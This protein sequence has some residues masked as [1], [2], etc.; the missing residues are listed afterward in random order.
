MAC[1][2]R[3]F[4]DGHRSV[5]LRSASDLLKVRGSFL[6]SS[7]I[8]SKNFQQT[9]FR[10][11]SECDK[12]LRILQRQNREYKP[13]LINSALWQMVTRLRHQVGAQHSQ[14]YLALVRRLPFDK[15]Y[16]VAA[17]IISFAR[18]LLYAITT[19]IALT[20]RYF[21]KTII[22]IRFMSFQRARLDL[23][24]R[25]ISARSARPMQY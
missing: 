14:Y 15:D 11:R 6:P 5:T 25:L 17:T 10:S 24:G 18:P 19:A 4:G 9:V 3:R 22:R 21:F 20:G 12:Q 13:T 1:W 7:F 23:L 16:I 8:T 2:R